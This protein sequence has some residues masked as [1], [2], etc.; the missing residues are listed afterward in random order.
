MRLQKYLAD[1]GIA[2][3]RKCEELIKEGRVKVNGLT[4]EIGATVGEGDAVFLDGK[5][6]EAA[7]EKVVYAFYKPKNVIC[8]SAEDEDRVKVLDYF[9]DEGQRLY[10]VGRLDYD[11]E[12]LIFVTNDGDLAERLT[13][14]RY[15]KSKTYRVLCSGQVSRQDER[16][17]KNGVMLEDGMTA[18]AAVRVLKSGRERSE[19]LISIHEGRNRQVRRMMAA[20]GHDTIKLCRIAIGDVELGSM[21]PGEKRLL[22]KE[23][24]DSFSKND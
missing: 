24:I 4:A 19:I 20:I 9:R 11:S 15:M 6:V 10:T 14:P 22:T 8:T 13:H 23:E 16:T 2:S 17:L 21:K 3:R 5:K 18:P 1:A 7:A 12:G